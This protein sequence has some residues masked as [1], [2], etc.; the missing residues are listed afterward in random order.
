MEVPVDRIV[1]IEKVVEVEKLVE[2]P[3]DRIVEVEKVVE[4][5]KLV[6]VPVDRIVEIEKV[7]EVE[8]VVEVVQSDAPIFAVE[9]LQIRN[10]V[11]DYNLFLEQALAI[12]ETFSE[13]EAEKLFRLIYEKLEKLNPDFVY[14]TFGLPIPLQEGQVGTLFTKEILERTGNLASD[15]WT[16]RRMSDDY[17]SSGS[18]IDERISR[19]R[20]NL[21]RIR[22]KTLP[23][24]PSVTLNTIQ[25]RFIESI[26]STMTR[27]G[28]EGEGFSLDEFL[29][30]EGTLEPAGSSPIDEVID[31]YKMLETKI[32]SN[33]ESGSK[34]VGY[35]DFQIDLPEEEEKELP[36]NIATESMAKIL[37]QQGK[38][39]QAVEIY[40]KLMLK[41][42]NKKAYFEA[43]IQPLL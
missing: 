12:K 26:I 24:A 14:Q 21:A 5:E 23:D 8:R 1:E 37:V 11:L 39:E 41:F 27:P 33:I 15:T 4:V 17:E 42:P 16:E 7:V 28:L 9:P 25:D 35:E 22:N 34:T 32:Y 38:N 2:V 19:F 3:V 13:N 18:N 40:R 29:K 31:Q 20:S 6:E 30:S 36:P 10:L 43:Q